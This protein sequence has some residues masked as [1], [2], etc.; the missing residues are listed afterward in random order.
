MEGLLP[1]R[2]SFGRDELVEEVNT[3]RLR[4]WERAARGPETGTAGAGA[5]KAKARPRNKLGKV[6]YRDR[7]TGLAKTGLVMPD[8]KILCEVPA[9]GRLITFLNTLE[10]LDEAPFTQP[11]EDAAA[12]GEQAARGI[13]GKLGDKDVDEM[14]DLAAAGSGRRRSRSVTSPGT[15]TKESVFM[16]NTVEDE[17]NAWCASNEGGDESAAG[18]EVGVGGLEGFPAEA[19]LDGTQDSSSGGDVGPS[20][21]HHHQH[22]GQVQPQ[23]P[24]QPPSQ[25]DK[26]RPA[27]SF[28]DPNNLVVASRLV[29]GQQCDRIC[30]FKGDPCRLV[31]DAVVRS[32]ARDLVTTNRGTLWPAAWARAC[33]RLLVSCE[34]YMAQFAAQER[35]ELLPA[36]RLVVTP[37]FDLPAKYILHV[38]TGPEGSEPRQLVAYYERVLQQCE[39][40][41]K[42]VVLTFIGDA[43]S[44]P[45]TTVARALVHAVLGGCQDHNSLLWGLERLV[46]ACATDAEMDAVRETIQVSAE[47]KMGV[48]AQP[49]S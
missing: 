20:P 16:L 46:I 26:Q 44:V 37:A 29:F 4:E 19:P 35:H 5:P 27:A 11:L 47:T 28:D 32:C 34:T 9:E 25:Q 1:A 6:A 24:A 14:Y 48:F 23:P 8:G 36:G 3:E 2:Y 12:L 39:D 7:S 42:T 31:A 38:A 22:H 33:P 15:F 41:Y 10:W 49:P 40:H 45:D 18:A 30:L 13:E 17:W 21:H 43:D